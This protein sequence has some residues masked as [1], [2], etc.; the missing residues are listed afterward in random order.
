[1]SV[2]AGIFLNFYEGEYGAEYYLEEYGEGLFSN[3]ELML[4]VCLIL[5]AIL[6]IGGIV[7]YVIGRKT[8]SPRLKELE[9]KRRSL[10]DE[11]MVELHGKVPGKN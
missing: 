1:M 5:G 9:I 3:F 6:I 2:V 8:E 11:L 7:M 10:L 4:Q